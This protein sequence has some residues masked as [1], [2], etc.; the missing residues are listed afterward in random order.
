MGLLTT[1]SVSSSYWF[2]SI[3]TS[4]APAGGHQGEESS[5]GPHHSEL[6]PSFPVRQ[7]HLSLYRLHPLTLTPPGSPSPALSCLQDFAPT[8]LS[9]LAQ[10]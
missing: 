10:L 8:I 5:V 9:A 1:Q 2:C 6:K 7:L 3:P 4:H